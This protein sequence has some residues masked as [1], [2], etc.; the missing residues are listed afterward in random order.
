MIKA[1]LPQIYRKNTSWLQKH[2]IWL[3]HRCGIFPTNP[4]TTSLLQVW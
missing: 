3:G 4:S 1:S 2:L